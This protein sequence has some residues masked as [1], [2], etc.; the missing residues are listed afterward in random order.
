M[1][2]CWYFLTSVGLVG[3]GGQPLW[4]CGAL[5]RHGGKLVQL[6]ALHAVG[7]QARPRVLL[8][9][10]STHVRLWVLPISVV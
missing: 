4:G 8:Q 6:A 9:S 2:G 7:H 3:W 5:Q 10:R 1:K